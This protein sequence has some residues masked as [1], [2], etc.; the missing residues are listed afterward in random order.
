MSWAQMIHLMQPN[1]AI[2][3]APKI[4]KLKAAKHLSTSLMMVTECENFNQVSQCA[5]SCVFEISN[6]PLGLCSSSMVS[7]IL[8][9]YRAL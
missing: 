2:V 6:A 7:R 8:T 9:I 3:E 4:L 5:E 1:F